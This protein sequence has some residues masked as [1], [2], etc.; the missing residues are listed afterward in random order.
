M[1]QFIPW[2]NRISGKPSFWRW[3][4]DDEKQTCF[5][6]LFPLCLVEEFETGLRIFIGDPKLLPQGTS[7]PLG[8][9]SNQ[10]KTC[11]VFID[12]KQK[13]IIDVIAAHGTGCNLPIKV[14]ASA[15]IN[16]VLIIFHPKKLITV[17]ATII[18]KLIKSLKIY[19][20]LFARNKCL[21]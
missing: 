6:I 5:L 20:M 19:N 17:V 3:C 10:Q 16:I 14:V 2:V 7:L 18:F 4:N 8:L 9:M 21:G 12:E 1:Q 11:I 15:V 13:S